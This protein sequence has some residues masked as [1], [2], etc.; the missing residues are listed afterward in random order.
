V[1]KAVNLY[2]HERRKILDFLGNCQLLK[3]I[4]SLVIFI[5]L[6]TR[7]V[8]VTQHAAAMFTR[9]STA[10]WISTETKKRT[11]DT[12]FDVTHKPSHMINKTCAGTW[13]FQR[14]V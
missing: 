8:P 10:T 13:W 14:D 12:S 11:K 2:V 3:A 6:F 4:R 5:C 9:Y 1:N 7:P